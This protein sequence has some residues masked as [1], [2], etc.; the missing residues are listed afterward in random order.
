MKNKRIGTVE[1]VAMVCILLLALVG[2]ITCVVSIVI[3]NSIDNPAECTYNIFRFLNIFLIVCITG[4]ILQ[5]YK[6]LNEKRK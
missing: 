6:E 4:D 1:K 2:I 5:G 3:S